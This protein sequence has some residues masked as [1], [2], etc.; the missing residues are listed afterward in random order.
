M[1][2]FLLESFHNGNFVLMRDEIREVLVNPQFLFKGGKDLT[3]APKDEAWEEAFEIHLMNNK[4]SVLP[5]SPKCP[6]LCTFCLQNNPFL[7]VIPLSFFQHMP[8]LQ[9][10]DLSH[11]KIRSLPHSLYHLAQLQKLFLR[12]CKLFMEL[13]PEVGKL[14]NLKVLDLEGTEIIRLPVDVG[15]LTN[16]TC[17]KM[18]F[19][20]DDDERKHDRYSNRLIIPQNVVS[21][22]FQLEELIIDVNPNDK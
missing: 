4:F 5:K 20:G 14:H 22:L 9:V 15:K 18:S 1:P 8:M 6:Q 2:A 11:T 12:G 7:R 10:L 17:L 16:L 21:N 13:P 3:K 19:Y